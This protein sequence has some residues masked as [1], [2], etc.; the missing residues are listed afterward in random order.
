MKKVAVVIL[1]YKVKYLVLKCLSSIEKSSY[2]NLVIVVVDNDSQDGLRDCLNVSDNLLF[3]Q[4][5]DN[6]GYA[7]GNNSGIREALKQQADFIFILNP[8]TTI[9]SNTIE[10]LVEGIKRNQADL[11]NPKIYFAGSRKLWFAGKRMDLA[12]VIASHIGVDQED[13]GQY[14]QERIINDVTGGALLVSVKVFQKVGLFDERYFMYYE[15][16]DLAMRAKKA[17]FKAVYVPSAIVYHRNAQSSGLGSSLQDYF[18]T[19]NRMLF[20]KKFL[21]HRIRFAL[22][23]EAAKNVLNPTRRLALFD[24][25]RGNFGKG[26][27]I[28]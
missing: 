12:N 2:P 17:G 22:L 23:R 16:S 26:S 19:R 9:E 8:D 10:K 15:D 4:N 1:N 18:I 20:A 6:L 28:K 24:Y 13:A 3:I 5:K 21:S 14:N 11:A 27:F 25:I 7:G